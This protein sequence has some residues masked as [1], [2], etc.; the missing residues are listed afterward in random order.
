MD[1]ESKAILKELFENSKIASLGTSNE[2]QPF[3]SMVAFTSAQ[4]FSEFYIHISG[5]AKHTKNIFLNN[6]ISLMICQPETDS[7]NPQTLA[8][9]SIIGN[10]NI[11]DAND[12]N[13]NEIKTSYL[14][15]YPSAKL[16]FNLGDFQL[17]RIEV[18][19]TRYVAGFAKTFNL[20]KVSLQNLYSED[21]SIN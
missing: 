1:E 17:F 5:L 12:A 8:R 10:A 20:T 2:N 14:S 11:V 19:K 13:Y 7:K 4:D 18:E 21:L 9:V 6:K 16:Y 15:K 3:V